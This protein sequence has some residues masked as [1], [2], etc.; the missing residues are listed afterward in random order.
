MICRNSSATMEQ[1]LKNIRQRAPDAEICIVDTFSNDFPTDAEIAAQHDAAAEHDALGDRSSAHAVVFFEAGVPKSHSIAKH[2]ADKWIEWAG[3]Q[4]TWNREME[5]FDDAAAARNK[6]YEIADPGATWHLWVDLDDA[7]PGAEETER[8]LKLNGMWNP[9]QDNTKE[10]VAPASAPRSL[11]DALRWFEKNAPEIDNIWC[12]YLYQHKDGKAIVWQQRERFTRNNGQWTWRGEAHEVRVPINPLYMPPKANLPTLLFVHL[13]KFDDSNKLYTVKRH[14]DVLTKKYEA[15]KSLSTQEWLYLV[16]YSQFLCP[17]LTPMYISKARDAANSPWDRARALMCEG[18][19]AA[20]NGFHLDALEAFGAATA[21]RPDLPDVWFEGAKAFEKSDKFDKAAEWYARGISCP[22]GLVESEVPPR[23]QQFDARM[24]AAAANWKHARTALNRLDMPVA[25]AAFERARVLAGEAAGVVSGGDKIDAESATATAKNEADGMLVMDAV[26]QVFNYLVRNDETEKAAALLKVVPWNQTDHPLTV[27][28][29]KFAAKMNKHYTDPAA[30]LDFY[31]HQ[32]AIGAIFSDEDQATKGPWMPRTL[33][34]IDQLNAWNPKARLAEFGTFDGVN[35][36]PVLLQMPGIRATAVEAFQKAI[37]IM[38]ERA[39]RLGVSDRLTTIHGLAGTEGDDLYDAVVAFEIIEHVPDPAIFVQN[40]L[41]R[42][43]PGGRLFLSTPWGAYDRG[44]PFNLSVRDP[45]GHVRAMNP[46][47]M[48][49][50]VK[51]AGGRILTLDGYKGISGV[52]ATMTCVVEKLEAHRPHRRTQSV[53]FAIAGSLWDWNATHVHETGIG[54]SE[55]TIVYLGEKLAET[56]DVA[57]Y[58][59]IPEVSGVLDE[60]TR[61]GVA[62]WPRER[63]R[64]ID[65]DSKVVVSR[66]PGLGR[67]LEEHIE[68]PL[69]KILWLQDSYYPNLDKFVGDYEKIVV[70]SN[71]HRDIM[72]AN[73]QVPMEKMEIIG[74]FLLEHQFRVASPPA[75]VPHRFIYAS[76]PDRGLIPLLRMWPEIR[77]RLPDAELHIFYGWAGAQKLSGVSLEWV[78]RYKKIR[79][80]YLSLCH[81]PGITDHGRVNHTQNALELMK[82]AAYLYPGDDRPD[83]Y[84]A[85]GETGCLN[86]IKARAAGCVMV[87]TPASALLETAKCDWTQ[88]VPL[89]P[90]KMTESG[91][92]VYEANFVDAVEAAVEVSEADRKLMSEEAIE[93]WR[94]E[95]IYPKWTKLLG[96]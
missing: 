76:S 66:A 19:F 23:V 35:L 53:T 83:N 52:G 41:R 42:L 28:L 75:R 30:Y 16:N 45:R 24:V 69:S 37:D 10:S 92:T 96:G 58:G 89:S 20:E 70:L 5:Y 12:P 60:E 50:C 33:W 36:I 93:Q 13:K 65:P 84:G 86:A 79:A 2:F 21:V 7:F 85:F 61:A 49:A 82:S 3:P 87:C 27:N 15:Q 9:G 1:T 31:E 77:R 40:L 6:S 17:H 78:T 64:R 71:W 25:Y 4:G 88:Y 57:V 43:V 32:E 18:S 26:R 91:V 80:E 48:H 68:K 14:F 72:H 59:Q 51:S 74:N 94:L 46:T 39:V 54:A 62:Y 22:V 47:D 90:Y 11:E 73:H 81:Q 55:E 29:E 95:A 8:L 44:D 67:V 56:R 34:L 38:R 63:F